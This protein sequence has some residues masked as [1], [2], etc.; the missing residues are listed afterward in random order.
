[1]AKSKKKK[2]KLRIRAAKAE[3]LE[4]NAL[5]FQHIHSPMD[6]GVA[7]R[8]VA[9]VPAI[10]EYFYR[11]GHRSLAQVTLSKIHLPEHIDVAHDALALAKGENFQRR[12]LHECED[13]SVHVALVQDN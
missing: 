10:R 7:K 6:F 13:V 2:S 12:V 5:I 8:Q 3:A 1:M 4:S 11:A 9:Q